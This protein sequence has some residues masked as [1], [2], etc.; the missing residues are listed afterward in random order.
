MA[1]PLRRSPQHSTEARLRDGL[2]CGDERPID[3]ISFRLN[4]SVSRAVRRSTRR[5]AKVVPVVR[6]SGPTKWAPAARKPCPLVCL[7]QTN[8]QTIPAGRTF[9]VSQKRGSTGGPGWILSQILRVSARPCRQH[10]VRRHPRPWLKP[11]PAERFNPTQK[12]SSVPPERAGPRGA[13]AHHAARS[14]MQSPDIHRR[15]LRGMPN[16]FA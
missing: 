6:P 5:V 2:Q 3:R 12:R 9:P 1:I 16:V 10:G 4:R 13:H 11:A 8:K 15:L 7:W 14:G